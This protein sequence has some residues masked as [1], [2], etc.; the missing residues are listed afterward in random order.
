VQI[1]WNNFAGLDHFFEYYCSLF[2]LHTSDGNCSLMH[3]SRRA[4]NWSLWRHDSSPIC[5]QR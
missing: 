5:N 2:H 3:P 1:G 4:T